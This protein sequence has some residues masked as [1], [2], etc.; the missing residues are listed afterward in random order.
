MISNIY[1]YSYV[2]SMRY[3]YMFVLSGASFWGCIYGDAET[4]GR[5]GPPLPSWLLPSFF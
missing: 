1:I 3:T 2:S 4:G 5:S